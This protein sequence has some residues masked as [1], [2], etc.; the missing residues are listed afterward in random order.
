MATT[1]FTNG[2]AL[3]IAVNDNRNPA[4][5]LPAVGRDATA[6][7]DVLVH[8]RRCAYPPGNVRLLLGSAATRAGIHAGLAWLRERIMADGSGNATAIL[9]YSGHGVYSPGDRSYY[10]LPYDTSAPLAASLLRATDLAA[11]IEQVQPRRLL[12]ALDCCHAGGMGIKGDDLAGGLGL[13]KMAAPAEARPIAAL[14]QGQG[15]AV[16]S[17]STA[18]ESSYIRPDRRM[19]IFTYHLVEALTGHA[20]PQGATEVLVSDLMG[21]VSRAVPGSARTAY[22]VAQTPVYQMSGENFPVALVL[23]GAGAGKGQ[24]LPDPLAALPAAPVTQTTILIGGGAYVS[25]G[26]F[27]AGGDINLGAMTA[28]SHAARGDKAVRS[29]NGGEAAAAIGVTMTQAAAAIQRAPRGDAAARAELNGLVGALQIELEAAAHDHEAAARTAARRLA[30]AAAALAE[31]DGE[32]IAI[33][34]RA[35]ARAAA[36]LA[37]DRT[38]IPALAGQITAAMA[39]LNE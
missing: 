13:Q 8:P 22:N 19:S 33:R 17:S 9:F 32:M 11:E 23:G 10:L 36:A 21:Y 31:G 7:R 29:G 15:R 34:G 38:T 6:L 26:A 35:L 3:I 27:T 28:G 2:Y 39:R 1:Q 5:A 20:Q 25:G 18:A 16:L 24:P 12:V 37:D 4:Y 30:D 14:M